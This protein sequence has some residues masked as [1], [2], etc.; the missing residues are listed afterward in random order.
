MTVVNDFQTAQTT[1]LEHHGVEADSR[2]FEVP[3]VEGR[4]HALVSG[5]G[6]PIV[7]VPGFADPCAMWASLMAELEGFKLYAVDRPRFGLTDRAPYGTSTFRSLAIEFLEQVLDSLGLD[8][9]LFVGNSIGS[10]WTLWLA[11]DRPD[12]LRR[13]VHIGC[14]AFVLGTSAP[15]PMRLLSVP[16]IGRVIMS[17]AKPSLG[18][19]KRFAKMAGED[20]S[21]HVELQHLLVAAQRM[22]GAQDAILELLNA[23]VRLRGARPE[24]VLDG[25]DLSQI[26]QPVLLIWGE[27]DPFGSVTVAQEITSH[28]PNAKLETVSDGGHVPWISNPSEVVGYMLPFLGN[29]GSV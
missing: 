6:P 2:F 10:L 3:S 22:P 17:L 14:P 16:P 19:V 24:L 26:R 20:L 12:R 5:E 15:L 28:L 27:R 8:R 11:L 23:V 13:M 9:P 4:V 1:L 21:D 29:A 25:E 7:M 18:Q